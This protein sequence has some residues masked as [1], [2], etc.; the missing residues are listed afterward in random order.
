[1]TV[2][3]LCRAIDKYAP[4][5]LIDEADTIFVNGG[6]N[7]ELR[8][9]LNAGLYRSNAFVLRC[10]GERHEPKVSSVW[11]PKAIALIGRL[12]ATLEDRSIVIAMQRRTLEERVE[13]FRY[14]NA[15]PNSNLETGGPLHSDH[16][17]RCETSNPLPEE[18]QTAQD[19]WS[20]LL[21]IADVIER[22]A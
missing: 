13:S 8:G 1:M 19:L 12:P 9:I 5:L 14:E 11:C 22:R 3:A 18:L 6:G 20:P 17:D 15:S 16:R 10:S 2:A 4:T 7:A 21:A